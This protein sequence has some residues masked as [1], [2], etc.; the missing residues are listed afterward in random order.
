VKLEKT[1]EES[2]VWISRAISRSDQF[3]RSCLVWADELDAAIQ[4]EYIEIA[5][6]SF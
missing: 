1:A 5:F 2:K 4:A 6:R 3:V